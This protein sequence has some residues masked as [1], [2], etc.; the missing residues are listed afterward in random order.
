MKTFVDHDRLYKELVSKHFADFLKLFAPRIAKDIDWHSLEFLDK[1]ITELTRGKKANTDLIVR[2]KYKNTPVFF[3]IH[4]EMQAS[5]EPGFARRMF[6]YYSRLL[7]KYNLPIYPIVL[8]TYEKP[9][10]AEPDC[11]RIDFP[12]RQVLYFWFQV[13][14]LNTLDWRKFVRSQNPIAC[15]L[16][17][18]MKFAPGDRPIIKLESLRELAKLKLDDARKGLISF[19]L[20]TYLKLDA[21]EERKYVAALNQVEPKE[22]ERVMEYVTSWEAKG[23]KVGLKKGREEGERIGEEKVILRQLRNRFGTLDEAITEKI[24]A[25][26]LTTLEKLSDALLEFTTANDLS[27]WLEAKQRSIPARKHGRNNVRKR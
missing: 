5:S 16:M 26:P 14:Q 2:V 7:E 10:R 12:G 8:C 19:F 21:H 9:K 15:A 4:I 20:D 22:K 3:I 18:R 24:Q 11:Y 23:I 27:T 13:I 1:E 6:L 17:S 25:L